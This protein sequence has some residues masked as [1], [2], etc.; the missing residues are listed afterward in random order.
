M[1]KEELL[2]LAYLKTRP[3]VFCFVAEEEGRCDSGT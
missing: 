3:E 1:E 2:Q